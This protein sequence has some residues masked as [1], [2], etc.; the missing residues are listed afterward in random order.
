MELSI[1]LGLAK[2]SSLQRRLD[3]LANNVANANT[4]GFRKSGVSFA[5][6]M[7]DASQRSPVQGE[8]GISYPF[9]VQTHIDLVEGA[10]QRTDNPLDI[11]LEGNSAAF[12]AVEQ[13]GRQLLTRSGALTMDSAG[14]LM[15]PGG[16]RL[17]GT[18]GLPIRLDPSAGRVGIDEL[19]NVV[20][21]GTTRGRIK[22]LELVD[23]T[24][25]E[26]VGK[27]LYFSFNTK[28]SESA[29]VRQGVLEN[30]N[31]DPIAEITELISL[32]RNYELLQ[33]MMQAEDNRLSDAIEKLPLF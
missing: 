5:S 15:V 7:H 10:I 4:M 21:D 26:H 14:E 12:L 20:Q 1:Y 17:L 32:S 24:D 33:Q 8:E 22:V 25:I 28:P 31:V 2:Q 11:A 19:G 23:R 13:D 3:V 6:Y 18:D 27:G 9:D 16:A 29:L 30:A